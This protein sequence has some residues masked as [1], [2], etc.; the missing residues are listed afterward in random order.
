MKKNIITAS[1]I[2]TIVML[3]LNSKD[4]CNP[5]FGEILIASFGG[6]FYGLW[7]FFFI[8]KFSKKN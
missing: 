1:I 5:S 6:L 2:F 8:K 4:Y 3:V 7:L